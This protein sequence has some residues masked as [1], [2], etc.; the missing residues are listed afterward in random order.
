MI[1]SV[2]Q[3]RKPRF[4][5]SS[6][7]SDKTQSPL[8][9]LSPLLTAQHKGLPV[10]RQST[11]TSAWVL[12][13]FLRH[14]QLQYCGL[15]VAEVLHGRKKCTHHPSDPPRRLIHAGNPTGIW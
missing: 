4:K 8:P 3:R 11:G 5:K 7:S 12:P 6:Y 14:A 13:A 9:S 15:T 2:L 1:M 10:V